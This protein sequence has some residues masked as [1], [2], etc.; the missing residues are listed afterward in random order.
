MKIEVAINLDG[1]RLEF[2]DCFIVLFGAVAADGMSYNDIW[3]AI[4]EKF[5]INKSRKWG[6]PDLNGV[7]KH[8]EEGQK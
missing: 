1:K 8:V 6:N 2:A 5:E 4:H 3:L 7:V